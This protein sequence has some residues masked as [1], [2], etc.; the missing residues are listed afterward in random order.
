M[1]EKEEEKPKAE[2]VKSQSISLSFIVTVFLINVIKN[3][4]VSLF[5]STFEFFKEHTFGSKK[6]P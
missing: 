1:T 3:I 5:V 4:F 6:K 2:E